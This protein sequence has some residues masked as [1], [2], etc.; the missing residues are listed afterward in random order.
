MIVTFGEYLYL[1]DSSFLL[2]SDVAQL[3]WVKWQQGLMLQYGNIIVMSVEGTTGLFSNVKDSDGIK[4]LREN[5]WELC[6]CVIE[7]MF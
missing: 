3:S 4:I 7:Q 5:Q 2:P 1:P 6:R